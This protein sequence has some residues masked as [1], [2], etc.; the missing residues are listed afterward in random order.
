MHA[1]SERQGHGTH[2]GSNTDRLKEASTI[3]RSLSALSLVILKL[4]EGAHVPYRNSKLTHI[5]QVSVPKCTEVL[6][7]V[8]A[9]ALSMV[10]LVPTEGAHV[11][12]H[13]RKLAHTLQVSASKDT[14]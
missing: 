5:L 14:E 10:A 13:N 7:A 11:P 1:G 3:N 8:I 9:C 12:D 4:T 2:A 6:C